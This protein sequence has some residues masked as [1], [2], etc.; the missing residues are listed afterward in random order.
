MRAFFVFL[1]TSSFSFSEPL[2][3][4]A[5]H[6]RVH[7][8]GIPHLLPILY[9]R[10]LH[11]LVHEPFLHLKALLSGVLAPAVTNDQR[12]TALALHLLFPALQSAY[13]SGG[14]NPD[15]LGSLV[16]IDFPRQTLAPNETR[17][18]RTHQENW[19]ISLGNSCCKSN[20]I[21]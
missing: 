17:W 5:G 15:F 14:F 9:N 16:A 8:L 20:S 10:P 1:I 7:G 3:G 12:P 21:N 6:V 19:P 2:Y 11:C 13:L 4:D 18:P